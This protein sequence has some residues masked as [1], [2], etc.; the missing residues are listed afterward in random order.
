MDVTARG[1]DAVLV[2][3]ALV[4]VSTHDC[5]FETETHTPRTRLRRAARLVH[6]VL[7]SPR[8]TCRVSLLEGIVDIY[9][10]VRIGC[11]LHQ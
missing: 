11:S 2:D 6:N 5:T 3:D 7:P 8:R 9:P 1:L 10:V 4:A